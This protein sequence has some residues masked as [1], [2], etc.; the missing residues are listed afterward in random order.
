MDTETVF[1]IIDMLDARF[2]NILDEIESEE[3]DAKKSYLQKH[4][5]LQYLSGKCE[6]LGELKQHLQEYIE[7]EVSK[8]EDQ[9]NEGG[10]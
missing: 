5:E 7:S 3:S 1:K 6:A 9:M 10:Y 4:I 2:K 8:A